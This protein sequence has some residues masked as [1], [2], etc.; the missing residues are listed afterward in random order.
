MKLKRR[1]LVLTIIFTLLLSC[2]AHGAITFKNIGNTYGTLNALAYVN[3]HL[4]C[5]C[6]N[7]MILTSDDEGMSLK[8][9]QF[10]QYDDYR[11]FVIYKNTVIGYNQ[12]YGKNIAVSSDSL[13]WSAFNMSENIALI[14]SGVDGFILITNS[15][16]LYTSKT[17]MEKT[18]K[19]EYT[20]T[21]PD[22]TRNIYYLDKTDTYLVVAYHNLYTTKDFKNYVPITLSDQNVTL[23][24]ATITDQSIYIINGNTSSVQVFDYNLNLKDTYQELFVNDMKIYPVSLYNNAGNVGYITSNKGV[25]RGD[26]VENSYLVDHN[27]AIVVNTGMILGAYLGNSVVINNKVFIGDPES[28]LVRVDLTTKKTDV[29]FSSTKYQTT[30]QYIND[31]II[32]NN[33]EQLYTLNSN[34]QKEVIIDF[35][36]SILGAHYIGLYESGE[37]YT[38][39]Y[40]DGRRFT[41]SDLKSWTAIQNA[42]YPFGFKKVINFNN[43]LMYTA[44]GTI[45]VDYNGSG[46]DFRV[47]SNTKDMYFEKLTLNSK[48]ALVFLDTNFA[49]G[50]VTYTDSII[51]NN[52]AYLAARNGKVTV[53]DKNLNCKRYD[54]ASTNLHNVQMKVINNKLFIVADGVIYTSA[55]GEKWTKLKSNGL[56]RAIDIA[57]GKGTYVIVGDS[58]SIMESTDLVSWKKID[59]GYKCQFE[60]VMFDGEKFVIGSF[61][62]IILVSTSITAEQ[63]TQQS[64][65]HVTVNG[66][67]IPFPDVIPFLDKNNRTQVPVRFVAE[68][69][70]G[71]VK[72]IS[73]TQTV[74]IEKNGDTI[75]FKI[76]ENAYSINGKKVSVDSSST[77][78]D[79]RTFVPLRF[80]SEAL[81]ATVKWN[82]TTNTVEISK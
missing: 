8:T 11:N 20:V 18:W 63:T 2:T 4:I 29:I 45:F 26:K 42:P 50:D 52:N 19:L 75:L 49:E 68:A 10:G 1:I 43:H 72:W 56:G 74:V 28:G 59:S 69:L 17:G 65:I 23:T 47:A 67:P 39:E 13:N 78:K 38:I 27:G 40:A 33:G 7:G 16:K 80:V 3:N 54:F 77:L 79:S 22:D 6:E 14:T 60:K 51:F 57:Y 36:S 15:G 25:Y 70:G 9:N 44:A 5:F 31:K 46:D 32:L 58:G 35:K 12:R 24:S 30:L 64:A 41:S 34:L 71:S 53:V 48:S 55:D 81:G 62:G 76:N 37:T 73:D 66:S 82:A 21:L 61:E